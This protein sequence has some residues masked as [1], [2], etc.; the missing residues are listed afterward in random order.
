MTQQTYSLR[1]SVIKTPSGKIKFRK[2][3]SGR[4]HYHI[5]VWLHAA[6][7]RALDQVSH[8]EYMLHTSFRQPLRKSSNR[9]NDFSIT[10][11]AW[12]AFEIVATIHF[13]DTARTSE[14]IH[15]QLD[16]RLPE[17]TGSNY[18]EVS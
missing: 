9:N 1:S 10:F 14:K 5:G 2:G 13:T 6:A 7:D 3:T 18:E 11:W 16:I 12:G 4:E 8:V 17:D 15:H